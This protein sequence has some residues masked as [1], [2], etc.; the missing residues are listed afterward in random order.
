MERYLQVE[1]TILPKRAMRFVEIILTRNDSGVCYTSTYATRLSCEQEVG[2]KKLDVGGA[3][4]G[5]DPPDK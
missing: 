5:G 1:L 3:M 4:E 2:N